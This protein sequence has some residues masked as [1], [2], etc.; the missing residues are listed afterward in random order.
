MAE[1][2]AYHNVLQNLEPILLSTKTQYVS[3]KRL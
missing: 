1:N 2:T 3:N